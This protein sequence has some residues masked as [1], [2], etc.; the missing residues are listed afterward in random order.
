MLYIGYLSVFFT[1]FNLTEQ[2]SGFEKQVEECY[3]PTPFS[4]SF[5]SNMYPMPFP[6]GIARIYLN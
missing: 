4:F 5:S 3:H 1:G 6:L 2:C